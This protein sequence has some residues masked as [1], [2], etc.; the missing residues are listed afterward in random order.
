MPNKTPAIISAVITFILLIIIS[1]MLSFGQLVALNGFSE[2]VGSISLVTSLI[3]QGVGNILAVIVAWRLA[4][5]FITKSNW[6]NIVAA[7]VSVLAGTLTGAGLSFI[8]II[9]SILLAEQIR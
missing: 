7:L 4:I 6:N 1:I 5:R 2:R 3:C 8:T 9:A